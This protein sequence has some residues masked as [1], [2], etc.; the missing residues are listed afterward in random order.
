MGEEDEQAIPRQP[1]GMTFFLERLRLAHLCREMTDAIPMQTPE[2]LQLPYEHIIA[3]DMKLQNFLSTL[4]L[5]FQVD[6]SSRAQSKPLEDI[7]PK[8]PI[9]RYCIITDAHSR[10]F[11]LH[12]K[13]L[14]RQSDDPRYAYSR[15]ACLES[16]RTVVKVYEDLREHD[17]SCTELMG[18][19]VH[20]T[21]LALVVLTMDLCFNK[22]DA[23]E[24]EIKAE[25]KAAL[26]GFENA[27]YPSPM[28]THLLESLKKV[29]RKH[30]VQL[31][32]QSTDAITVSNSISFE[33]PM[34]FTQLGGDMGVADHVLDTSFDEFWEI[35]MQ[36]AASPDLLLWDNMFSSVDLRPL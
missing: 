12:Q 19:A 23:H 1:T 17:S 18:M 28:V 5:F 21:H 24:S 2:L 22:E 32:D 6:P 11:K 4:P 9:L 3:M 35:A 13:F 34:L 8:T 14:P 15:Q 10:R 7:Y 29:L 30:N 20:F 36:G 31:Q 16:A 26:I 33:D 27:R 25:V